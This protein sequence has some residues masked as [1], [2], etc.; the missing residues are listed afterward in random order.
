MPTPWVSVVLAYCGYGGKKVR[1]GVANEMY[2][3]SKLC[4]G[5][6]RTFGPDGAI[7]GLSNKS[8]V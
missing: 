5:R 7:V 1:R 4:S 8:V 2:D 6:T 3:Y